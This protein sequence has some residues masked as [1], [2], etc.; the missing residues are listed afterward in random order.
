MVSSETSPK[1]D[2]TANG[3][4]ASGVSGNP[5]GRPKS[6]H[7]VIREKL[8]EGKDHVIAAV[9]KAARAGDM[10]AAKL[11]LDRLLPPLKATSQTIELA[12]PA[13]SSPLGIARAI[14]DAAASGAIPPDN[15]AQLVSAVG[16][17]CRIE[18]T[19]EL[20]ERIAAL[21]KAIS[22]PTKKP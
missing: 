3:T 16:T 5:N 9:L 15:A 17:F 7:A 12:L 21:E 2:R 13:S 1:S 14:L 11:V 22:S 20:R 8:A 19:E 4:F 18:E 6:H 10:T